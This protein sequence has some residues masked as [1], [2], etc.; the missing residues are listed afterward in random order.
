MIYIHELKDHLEHKQRLL[1]LIEEDEGNEQ[2]RERQQLTKSDW[3]TG[4]KQNNCTRSIKPYMDYFLKNNHE[5]LFELLHKNIVHDPGGV[6]INSYWYQ[7]YHTS[8]FQEWH[9][10]RNCILA[11]VYYLELP[12]GSPT[13]EFWMPYTDGI[14]TIDAKEGDVIVFPSF[15]SHRSPPNKS[16]NRKTVIAWNCS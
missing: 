2:S 13:T 5:Q 3:G 8:D 6:G 15:L 7:Q 14:T 9:N 1:D 16:D 11:C 12:E 4:K 10:H